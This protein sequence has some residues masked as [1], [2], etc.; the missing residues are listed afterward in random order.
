MN[1]TEL[2]ANKQER[3]IAFVIGTICLAGTLVAAYF[4]FFEA[5]NPF[6]GKQVVWNMKKV[7]E[8]TQHPDDMEYSDAY[9]AGYRVAQ[10]NGKDTDERSY[11]SGSPAES[12]TWAR[13][14]VAG[15]TN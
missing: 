7:F 3:R 8:V 6:D 4:G 1:E 2:K 5:I 15:T 14:F 9:K 11:F 10:G 13:G 12:D